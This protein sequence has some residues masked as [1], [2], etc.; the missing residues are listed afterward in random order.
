VRRA[1]LLTAVLCACSSRG[2]AATVA[3]AVEVTALVNPLNV[4]GRDGASTAVLWGQ[5][6]WMYGDTFLGIPN[7][8]GFG[9]VSNTF[10]T[11]ALTVVDGTITLTQPTD[12]AGSPRELVRPTSDELA[13]DDLHAQLPDGG[14]SVTPC[15]G[16]YATWPTTAVFDPADGGSALIFY[17]LETAAPGDFNF[18]GI[19]AAVALWTDPSQPPSR[20]ELGF[21]DGVPTA[22]FCANE[23]NWGEAA[24]VVDGGVYTIACTQGTISNSCQLARV[25]FS[26]ALDKTAWQYWDGTEWSSQESSAQNIF[27]GSFNMNVYFNAH[28]GQWMVIYSVPFSNDVA[29]RTAPQLTGPWSDQSKLFTADVAGAKNNAYDA[30]IHPELSDGTGTELFVTYSRSN[31]TLF[32]DEFVLWK[33]T[34]K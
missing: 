22:M 21:C 28:V 15:G 24:V 20:P 11:S 5:D 10:S 19:G 18:A 34:F 13:Y 25:P 31:G 9:F 29:Y 27:D 2:P 4:T 1:L 14:C 23:P 33:V 17:E 26:Q 30:H 6:I 3:S 32:G 7:E 12:D 16:R 8:D